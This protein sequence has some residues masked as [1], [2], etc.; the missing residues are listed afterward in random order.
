LRIRKAIKR[1]AA[2]CGPVADHLDRAVT[3]GNCCQY[4]P[5]PGPRLVV[6]T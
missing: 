5:P 1:I 3:T 6:T 2:V 4:D